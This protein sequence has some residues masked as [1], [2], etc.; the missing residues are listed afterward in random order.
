[1]FL[2][3]FIFIAA[4]VVMAAYNYF[5]IRGLTSTKAWHYYQW[6]LVPMLVFAGW[7]LGRVPFTWHDY[8]EIVGIALLGVPVYVFLLHYLLRRF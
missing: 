4:M 3:A 5:S 8:G 2:P 7:L 1:M 6:S